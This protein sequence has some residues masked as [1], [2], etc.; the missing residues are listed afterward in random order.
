MKL[1]FSISRILEKIILFY[2]GIIKKPTYTG[3]I[4]HSASN[5]P[6]HY[7]F[8]TAV[9]LKNTWLDRSSAVF[10][11]EILYELSAV[12]R[13][14]GYSYKFINDVTSYSHNHNNN[15]NDNN[16]NYNNEHNNFYSLPY[17]GPNC[18]IIKKFLRKLGDE[19]KIAFRSHNTIGNLFFSFVKDPTPLKKRSEVIYN[20]PCMDCPKSYVGE[21]L[22]HLQKRISRH[23][24]DEKALNNATALAVHAKDFNHKFNFDGI[25]ILS[26]ESN[27]RKRKTR[28]VIEILKKDTVN[29]KSDTDGIR[30][31]YAHL[32]KRS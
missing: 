8:N 7:K 27:T 11:N 20:I 25:Q 19:V 5:Q 3:R 29:F 9:N 32:F 13:D 16:N 12:L 23:K 17:A 24:S 21:T 2:F 10:H 26:Y 30:H 14:N 4:I 6:F 1:I 15:T 28:E 22:Q 31:T 18:L